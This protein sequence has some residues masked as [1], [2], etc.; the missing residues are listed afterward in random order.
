MKADLLGGVRRAPITSS[1]GNWVA[2]VEGQYSWLGGSNNGIIFPG[3]FVYTDDPG[4]HS[5]R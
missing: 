1:A 5:A 4:V 2:G 3:G